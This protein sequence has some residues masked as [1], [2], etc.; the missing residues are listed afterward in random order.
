MRQ[1]NQQKAGVLLSYVNLA[2]GSIIPI[3]YTPIMLSILGQ[4]EYGLYNL[5][6][7]VTNYL[8]LLNLGMGSAFVRY[9]AKYRG[10][11]NIDGIK[12]LMGMFICIYS[13][14]A[15]LVCVGGGILSVFADNLFAE[16]LTAAEISRL[17]ILIVLMAVNM[18]ISMPTSTFNS[19]ATAFE[20]FAFSKSLAIVETI[21]VPGLNLAI[22]YMGGGSI[23]MAFVALGV[24]I[25]AR[26]VTFIF[27]QRK[28][29]I[30]P[31]F[32]N[33]PTH[34]L[35][36]IAGYCFFLFLSTIVDMLYWSTDKVMIGAILGTA[37]VA[38]Y[39]VGGVF[40]SM[41][42]NFAQAL[43]QVFT[44]RIVMMAT[45][46]DQSPKEISDLMIRI[47]RLQFFIVSFILAG[48][49]V[50]GQYFLRLWLKDSSYD[51]AYYIA[52][53]TM[54]PLAI[55]L[56][57]SIAY[58]TMVAQNKHQFRAI[59]YAV[60]A[61]VNAVSTY[62]VL[63]RFG[64]IGAAVCTTVAFLLGNG[65]IMNIY[66]HRVIKLDIP[67]FW[68]NILRIAIIPISLVVTGLLFVHYIWPPTSI[69][70]FLGE[71][72][73]FSVI[74]WALSWFLS[75]NSY[76]KQLLTGFIKKRG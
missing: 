55:P 60:I 53:L 43:S 9:A 15:L 50:F 31:R 20:R 37:M 33:M 36:E 10:E 54:V 62:L 27:C 41:M 61:V 1:I 68:L 38:V 67:R 23:G 39:N 32:K 5:S 70:I 56:I 19:I 30:T 6:A 17:R 29:K 4:Q 40:T 3:I 18:A 24:Q 66:Y 75:L 22:L 64:I 26:A 58:S 59:I 46:K 65:I 71:V 34:L 72:A 42:Q 49:T 69:P 57:Q 45:K 8:S 35:K 25:A 12:K 48:Y 2:L 11:N 63:R 28:L 14:M 47:G 74:F 44:P 52:L 16:G 21:A 76:E 13:A 51:S 7:S 73:A